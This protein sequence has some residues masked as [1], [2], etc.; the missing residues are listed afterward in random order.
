MYF[1]KLK[2]GEF[3]KSLISLLMLI[4]EI[5]SFQGRWKAERYLGFLPVS[6]RVT[7]LLTDAPIPCL[8]N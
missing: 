6:T 8:L 2:F 1:G 7:L 5:I 3:F 4:I